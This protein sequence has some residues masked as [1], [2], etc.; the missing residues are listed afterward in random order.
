MY[1]SI[2][3]LNPHVGTKY[4]LQ[5]GA[6]EPQTGTE[7]FSSGGQTVVHLSSCVGML[8]KLCYLV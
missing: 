1:L 7:K 2:S 6:G 3:L 5:V 4:E 8:A